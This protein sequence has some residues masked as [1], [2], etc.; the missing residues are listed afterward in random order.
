[1]GTEPTAAPVTFTSPT[2]RARAYLVMGLQCVD[3]L[4]RAWSRRDYWTARHYAR[5]AQ[6]YA[7]AARVAS[8]E[9]L[10]HTGSL[11][12]LEPAPSL[13]AERCGWDGRPGSCRTP[14]AC[15]LLADRGR[16]VHPAAEPAKA[17]PDATMLAYQ[18]G[19]L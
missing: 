1:M 2:M 6:E 13:H 4:E 14:D 11:E 7:E 5:K 19:E 16:L 8:D 12:E 3:Q 17:D 18:R 10:T 9:A 15:R